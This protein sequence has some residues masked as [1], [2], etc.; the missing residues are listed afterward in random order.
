MANYNTIAAMPGCA[1]SGNVLAETAFGIAPGNTVRAFCA[2]PSFIGSS[3]LDGREIVL[4]CGILVTTAGAFT[5]GPSIRLY[6]GGNTGLTTFTNDTAIVT[7][8]APTISTATRM[9]SIEARL[10]WDSTT[11]RL[12]GRYIWMVDT[13]STGWVTLTAGLTSG[14]TNASNLN[15]CLTGIFGTTGAN[16]AVLKY[17]E[18]DLV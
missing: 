3:S 6:S 14:V 13:T 4:R 11:A 16:T 7:P 5:Y 9:L 18:M 10:S 8:A 1:A 15:W 12:Q 2:M 17:F